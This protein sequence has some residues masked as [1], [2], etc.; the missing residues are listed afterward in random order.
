[1]SLEFAPRVN[2]ITGDN[3][4]GKSFILD[5]AWYVQTGHWAAETQ[6]NLSFGHQALP[7]TKQK[8]SI[9]WTV[10]IKGVK[11]VKAGNRLIEIAGSNSEYIT[12]NQ[13]WQ[14]NKGVFARKILVV[15]FAS[16]S[17]GAVY[18]P[19]RKDTDF[20]TSISFLKD[21]LW[22]G[23]AENGKSIR[24]G[25]IRDWA[26]WQLENGTTFKQFIA[27]LEGLS[28]SD[29]ELLQFGKLTSVS[30]DD[31]GDIPTLK[32]PYGQEVPIIHASAGIKRILTL[33]Y[34]VVWAWHEHLRASK[35][36]GQ[37]PTKEFVV[38]IDEIEQHLHPRWQK[39]ILESLLGF[40]HDLSSKGW[41]DKMLFDENTN[42]QPTTILNPTPRLTQP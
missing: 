32:M 17:S 34:L 33:A 2:I 29:E 25:L 15:Q 41:A 23:I 38:L 10:K 8:A 27:V 28:S 36:V 31:A 24:N 42:S 40:Y 39:V 6:P 11:T 19:A 3:G 22:N 37:E 18:D 12:K 16:D 26:R 13:K 20:S 5:V 4:L 35:L 14:M 9:E 21:E 30:L 7:Y 1:M